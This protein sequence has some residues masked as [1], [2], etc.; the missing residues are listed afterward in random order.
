MFTEQYCSSEVHWIVMH[1]SM[2]HD[3]LPLK[4]RIPDYS[5]IR[6]NVYDMCSHFVT[7]PVFSMSPPV[8]DINLQCTSCQK[9]QLL[10]IKVVEQI[11]WHHFRESLL[12]TLH[13]L[14][15][16]PIQPPAQHQV[17]VLMFV[18]LCDWEVYATFL[19][20]MTVDLTKRLLQGICTIQ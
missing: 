17:N 2:M 4:A 14:S 15:H 7:I 5:K 3:I 10:S 16:A 19:Q 8:V 18:V 13:L 20:L 11:N 9:L 1:K 12:E 6:F